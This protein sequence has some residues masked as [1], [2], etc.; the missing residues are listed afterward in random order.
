MDL[1][2][3]VLNAKRM[4]FFILISSCLFLNWVY[5]DD[6]QGTPVPSHQLFYLYSKLHIQ[7][8]KNDAPNISSPLLEIPVGEALMC[9]PLISS[10]RRLRLGMEDILCAYEHDLYSLHLLRFEHS[11]CRIFAL[12]NPYIDTSGL[13]LEHDIDISLPKPDGSSSYLL[14][15]DSFGNYPYYKSKIFIETKVS[16]IKL[17]GFNL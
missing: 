8:P 12:T 17:Q 5:L 6:A 2:S 9:D 1:K 14:Y 3:I 7:L 10:L 15:G 13:L 11:H 16:A 4:K